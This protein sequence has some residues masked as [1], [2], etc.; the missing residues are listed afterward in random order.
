MK[1]FE[2]KC[3]EKDSIKTLNIDLWNAGMKLKRLF[4]KNSRVIE[5]IRIDEH[6][7][8][9]SVRGE[10][11]VSRLMSPLLKDEDEEFIKMDEKRQY[12]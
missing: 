1:N 10:A 5:F 9:V 2:V 3:L 8:I 7:W 4:V 12:N 11:I 6:T